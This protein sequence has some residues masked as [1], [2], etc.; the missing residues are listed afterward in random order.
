MLCKVLAFQS[1]PGM[2]FDCNFVIKQRITQKNDMNF[3]YELKSFSSRGIGSSH[4]GQGLENKVDGARHFFHPHETSL[5]WRPC[6]KQHYHE[7]V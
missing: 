1:T 4:K 6:A 7:N 5:Q 3:L 2:S